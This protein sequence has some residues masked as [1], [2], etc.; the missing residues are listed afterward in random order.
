MPPK[1]KKKDI[2]TNSKPSNKT[3]IQSTI[4]TNSKND[5]YTL[6]YTVTPNDIRKLEER[7][8]KAILEKIDNK[9]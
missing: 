5:V 8:A 9:K 4:Q 6:K 3:T 1:I 7:V 2:L